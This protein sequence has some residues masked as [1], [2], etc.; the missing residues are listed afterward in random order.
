MSLIESPS[1]APPQNDIPESQR[2]AWIEAQRPAPPPPPPRVE[3]VYVS[4][5]VHYVHDHR[6]WDDW[7]LP[8]SLSLGYWSGWGGGHHGHG[9][10]HGGGWGW[11]VSYNS[12][13]WH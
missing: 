13:W 6:G 7:Y 4:E 8:I 3:R 2:R 1:V 12:S 10:D 9:H 11:G 5:P